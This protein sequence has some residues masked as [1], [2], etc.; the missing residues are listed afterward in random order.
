MNLTQSLTR[1]LLRFRDYITSNPYRLPDDP[2]LVMIDDLLAALDLYP[3]PAHIKEYNL[4]TW[5]YDCAD[6]GMFEFQMVY[7]DVLTAELCV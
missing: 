1:N 6:M 7:L 2:R 5:L 4:L 3:I